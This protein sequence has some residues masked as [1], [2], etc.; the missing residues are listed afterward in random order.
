MRHCHWNH[1]R[2][3]DY[4]SRKVR[5][6][7]KYAYDHVPFYHSS[8]RQ[9][10][11]K[12]DEIRSVEDLKKLPIVRKG[13][14][15]KNAGKTTSEEFCST[16]LIVESTSGSTGQPL[17]YYLTKSEN[18][19]RKAKLLRAN[20]GCGQK[21][22]DRWV[23]ITSPLYARRSSM[24]GIQKLLGIFA[25]MTASVF[26]G[27]DEQIALVNRARPDVLEG[28]SS[29]L[30]LMAKEIEKKGIA[31]SKPRMVIGGAD[32]LGDHERF[33]IEK[34]FDAPFYDQYGCNELEVLAW[35]CQEKGEYHIDADTVVM[36]FLDDNGEEVASGETG[37]IVC[38]SLFNRAM[39]FIRYAVGDVG[40]PSEENE[41]SCGR[42]FPLMKLVEGRKD[43]F[44]VLPNNRVV[45]PW[46]FLLLMR[47]FRFFSHIDQYRVIQKRVNLLEFQVK[48]K[49]FVVDRE[50]VKDELVKHFRKALNV[51]GDELALEVEFVNDVSLTKSGK[52]ATVVSEIE[53]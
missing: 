32:L 38:T 15:Q 12:P 16:K 27:T 41:C 40:V 47:E 4:Q 9:L 21:P 18:E 34:M 50:I 42:T 53:K 11:L 31:V 44:I 39:P 24:A 1:D 25:P 51:T 28:Y 26:D 36:E 5:E 3:V 23:V 10:G 8:F 46:V 7:V 14:L 13:E 17:L 49:E 33:F 37:E 19:F 52:L 6:I 22:R 2:L 43:S 20:I 29:S 48:M 45:S 35:Q 30:L